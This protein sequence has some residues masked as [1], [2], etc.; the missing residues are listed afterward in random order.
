VKRDGEKV[1]ITDVKFLSDQHLEVNTLPALFPGLPLRSLVG[2]MIEDVYKVFCIVQVVYS[3][4]K[5]RHASS[6]IVAVFHAAMPHN[7]A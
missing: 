2:G 7:F 1:V 3:L 4:F 6:S 5:E